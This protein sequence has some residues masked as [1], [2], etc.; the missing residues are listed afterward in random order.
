METEHPFRGTPP[1]ELR[2]TPP[3]PLTEQVSRGRVLLRLIATW[4]IL[5][6]A[7]WA[8]V[9]DRLLLRR[10]FY[11]VVPRR[12]ERLPWTRAM[13]LAFERLGPTYIKFGQ[14]IASSKGLFPEGLCEEMR[15]V[16]DDVPPEP[17]ERTR[18]TIEEMFDAPLA[19]LF[20]RF[21]EAPIAAASIAQVHGAT[22]PDGTDVVVKVQRPNLPLRVGADLRVLGAAARLAERVSHQARLGN[23]SGIVSDF[24]E[25]LTQEMDFRLEGLN[26]DEFNAIFDSQPDKH[27]C[28]PRVYWER[29]RTHALTMERF[30]GCRV[31]DVER[32]QT[33]E[34]PE[35]ELVRGV[36]AWTETLLRN[37]MFHGDV[38]AGN[39]M[40][41]DDGRIGFLDFGIVGRFDQT[42][43]EQSMEFLLCLALSNYK[44][45]AEIVIEMSD[46]SIDGRQLDV[47]EVA[48][49]LRS[50]YGPLTH[51]TMAEIE[52]GEVLPNI[53]RTGIKH[54]LRFPKEFVL[55][56]KQFLYFDRYARLLA[57]NLNMFQDPR[58][59]MQ[60]TQLLPQL[61]AAQPPASSPSATA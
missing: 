47:N 59:I 38:H 1:T 39:L 2:A 40:Y 44:R 53:Q 61:Q 52:Y 4:W 17:F 20:D 8:W 43:R 6:L 54:G 28:A 56:T 7:F 15:A 36:L 42:T 57:P 37:G 11:L 34:D 32:M 41:L 19:T 51:M 12:Y 25:T 24:V 13:R 29:T 33:L 26:M 48:E 9:A 22:L 46:G 49:D 16:L 60:I 18:A 45:F 55:I 35:A 14:V 21:E 10:V 31:D 50:A 27:V 3:Q 30:V 5:G 58:I 23:L